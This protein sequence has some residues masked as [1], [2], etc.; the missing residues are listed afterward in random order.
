MSFP[1]HCLRGCLSLA[2]LFRKSNQQYYHRL[3]KWSLCPTADRVPLSSFNWFFLFLLPC[4]GKLIPMPAEEAQRGLYQV[5]QVS[6]W[7]QHQRSAFRQRLLR[8]TW[9]PSFFLLRLLM[10]MVLS[11]TSSIIFVGAISFNSSRVTAF[12]LTGYEKQ[13]LCHHQSAWSSTQQSKSCTE[14]VD[15]LLPSNNNTSGIQLLVVPISRGALRHP[16]NSAAVLPLL[17]NTTGHRSP[18]SNTFFQT[19]LL[20]TLLNLTQLGHTPPPRL[21]KVI[22]VRSGNRSGSS[23][24]N[25]IGIG[26]VRFWFL[27]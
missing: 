23:I 4:T 10:P 9:K 24:S 17:E 14:L 22:T 8:V 2:L 1:S 7:N 25:Q 20:Y 11:A 18:T 16:T 26:S 27:F 21:H 15:C 19:G 13:R 6:P 12:S 3:D 5:N